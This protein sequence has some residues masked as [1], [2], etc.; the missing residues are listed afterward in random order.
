MKYKFAI[1]DQ[2]TI[3]LKAD[4]DLYFVEG[5]RVKWISKRIYTDSLHVGVCAVDEE[6]TRISIDKEGE[7]IW[8]RSVLK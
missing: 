3:D 8:V 4:G 2:K 5:V 1:K 6:K 7:D